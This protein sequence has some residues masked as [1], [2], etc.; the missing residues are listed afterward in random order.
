MRNK[1]FF[2]V[3]ALAAAGLI[4]GA[5]PAAAHVTVSSPTAT[6]GG[7]ST[8]E[9]SVPT[10]SAGARTVAVTVTL[11]ADHP[12]V[13]VR[14]LPVPGWTVTT[15][16]TKL[17]APVTVGAVSVTEPITSVTFTADNGGGIPPGA[18]GRFVLKIGPLPAVSSLS[19][20]TEQRYSDGTVVRWADPLPASGA[21]PEHPA[22]TLAI[23]TSATAADA[24]SGSAAGSW[25]VGL[26]AA[27]LL[28]AGAALLVGLR[29][30]PVVQAAAGQDRSD[31]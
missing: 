4:V 24:T 9:F 13:S 2:V 10:E 8:V 30:R 5:G 21:E 20:P 14:Y 17:A 12:L 16:T 15:T 23:G 27:A 3:G 22:P 1:R 25:G 18:F 7:Y 31:G 29:R 6:A 19:F 28:L 26:G 11:P